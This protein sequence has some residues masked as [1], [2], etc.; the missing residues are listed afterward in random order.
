MSFWEKIDRLIRSQGTRMQVA[1]R[2]DII[3]EDLRDDG[4]IM[5]RSLSDSGLSDLVSKE[6][7]PLLPTVFLLHKT[8]NVPF[9]ELIEALGYPIEEQDLD[10]VRARV[11]ALVRAGSDEFADLISEIASLDEAQ[12]QAVAAYVKLLKRP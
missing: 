3:A 5:P 7:M 9:R 1:A 10:P 12:Q 4:Y 6:R 2:S 11:A 8:L